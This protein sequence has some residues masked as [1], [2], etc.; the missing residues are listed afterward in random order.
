MDRDIEGRGAGGKDKA[1]R[2]WRSSERKE[3]RVREKEREG[4]RQQMD[5]ERK[6]GG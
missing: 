5:K 1:I 6:G 2:R 3:R 4:G